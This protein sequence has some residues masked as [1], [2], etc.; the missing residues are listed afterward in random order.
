MRTGGRDRA[1]GGP[2]SRAETP[3]TTGGDRPSWKRHGASASL[4][5]PRTRG[6]TA[7]RAVYGG[8]RDR[9]NRGWT[10]HRRCPAGSRVDALTSVEPA[11]VGGTPRPT[12]TSASTGGSSATARWLWGP[13]GWDEADLGLLGPVAGRRVLELGCGAASGARWL[14]R[15]G[16]RAVGLDLSGR[17]LQHSRRLDDAERLPVPCRR[18][19]PR[20]RAPV[21]RGDFD[22]VGHRLRRAAVRRRRRPVLAEVARVLVPGGRVALSVTHPVRWAFPRRPGRGRSHRRPLVLRPDA[23]RRDGR[24]GSRHLRRAPPHGR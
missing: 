10:G 19:G 16:R 8:R 14:R 6:P 15:P 7:L 9:V 24:V 3:W 1:R 21:P 20:G 5:R 13:E 12:A 23:L 22:V 4:L 2:I 17:M 18:A 11:A